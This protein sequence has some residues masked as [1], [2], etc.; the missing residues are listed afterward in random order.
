MRVPRRAC[1]LRAKG[2][3]AGSLPAAAK[4]VCRRAQLLPITSTLRT[5]IL[6]V[7]P[8]ATLPH[9]TVLGLARWPP[10]HSRHRS[11]PRRS[12]MIATLPASPPRLRTTSICCHQHS[13]CVTSTWAWVSRVF[14]TGHNNRCCWSLGAWL[15]CTASHGRDRTPRPAT[16]T[17][18]QAGPQPDL[19]HFC[20]S[21]T[22]SWRHR[23]ARICHSCPGTAVVQ[24]P[25]V[26]SARERVVV[27]HRHR[28]LVAITTHHYGRRGNSHADEG[29]TPSPTFLLPRDPQPRAGSHPTHVSGTSHHRSQR[30]LQH[31]RLFRRAQHA[32]R[33][34]EPPADPFGRHATRPG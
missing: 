25:R 24:H 33:G 22:W 30:L 27:A 14:P 21:C 1:S 4:R 6:V 19:S 3:T 20:I 32:T 2:H 15:A 28:I 5:D 23:L 17:C 29:A 34:I 7:I 31:L 12:C 26:F 8:G 11:H 10:D 13:R 16:L 9:G 18:H